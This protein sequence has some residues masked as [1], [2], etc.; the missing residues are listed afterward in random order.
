MDFAE[1]Q[2]L[3]F[4]K[5]YGWTSFDL[6]KAVKRITKFSK[7]GHAGTLDPLA[8][9]LMILC[10]GKKTKMISEFQE[11]VKVYTGQAVFGKTTPS[12]DR[13]T[14]PNQ[15]FPTDHIDLKLLQQ[16]A[17]LLSG[18]ISQQP[19]AYSALK[20]DGQRSFELARKGKEVSLKERKVM[21]HRFEIDDY[22]N[23]TATF[24]IECSKGTYVR[25]LINDLGKL[26]E[27]GAYLHDLKREKIGSFQISDAWEIKD[28]IKSLN[29]D[30]EVREHNYKIRP[31]F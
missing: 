31:V 23:E 18:E 6:V 1:G 26:A 8:S 13:E 4:N 2:V 29:S 24:S 17:L 22:R 30:Y 20:I 10:T 21:V 7:I 27:S 25:S 5:P 3:L 11:G 9:G 19:P 15:T 12:Y 14:Y 28:F 16:K